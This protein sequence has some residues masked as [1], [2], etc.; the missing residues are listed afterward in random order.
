MRGG[1]SSL[2]IKPALCTN[3]HILRNCVLMGRSGRPSYSDPWVDQVNWLPGTFM[4]L[5][6]V[7]RT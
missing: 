6:V 3:L 1:Y 5:Y 2:G 7:I 4:V